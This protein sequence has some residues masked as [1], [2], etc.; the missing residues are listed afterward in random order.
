MSSTQPSTEFG[1]VT[2][3]KSFQISRSKD[4]ECWCRDR[5]L[6]LILQTDDLLIGG[7]THET[8]LSFVA[9]QLSGSLPGLQGHLLVRTDEPATTTDPAPLPIHATSSITHRD[10][11]S[12]AK[13][14]FA[15]HR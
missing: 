10:L 13:E 5:P 6:E 7:H 2:L 4:L 9:G 1:D 8:H 14:E 12:L 11:M 3:E 15:K